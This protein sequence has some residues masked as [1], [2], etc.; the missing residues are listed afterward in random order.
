M[1]IYYILL[2]FLTTEITNQDNYNY[3]LNNITIKKIKTIRA[4][5]LLN[6]FEPNLKCKNEF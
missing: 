5:A 6:V 1:S 4:C 3:V 2:N